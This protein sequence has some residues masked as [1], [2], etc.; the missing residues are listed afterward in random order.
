MSDRITA[1]EAAWRSALLESSLDC[2]ILMDAAGVIIDVNTGVEA[3]FGTLRQDIIGRRLGDV[4]V[5][6]ELRARHEEGLQRY[7]TRGES[8]ILGRRIEV[9]ALHANGS[10]MAV[11]LSIVHLQGTDPAVFVGHLRTIADRRRSERRLRLGAAAGGI[12]STSASPEAAVH[13]V[14]RA[15]GDELG[16]PLVQFWRVDPLGE[17]LELHEWWAQSDVPSPLGTRALRRGE[18]LPGATWARGEAIWIEDVRDSP[19]VLPRTGILDLAGVQS[20]VCF[21]VRVQ[22]EIVAVIEAFRTDRE[23]IDPELLP[24]LEVLGAQLGHVVAVHDA[25]RLLEANRRALQDALGRAERANAAKDEFLA[26]VSHELRTP[27]GPIMGWA[28]FLQQTHVDDTARV[29]AADVILRN[30]Q[31]ETRLVE[32]LLDVSRIV[33]GKLTIERT[34]VDVTSVVEAAIETVAGPA[35][36]KGLQI[37]VERG[38]EMPSTLGDPKRLQQVFSNLLVNA[39]KFTP[40]G[41]RITVT[42][43]AGPETVEVR[44]RDTGKGITS[45]LLPRI[46]ERFR[47]GG[48]GAGFASSG[49]GIGLSLVRDLVAAHGG[50]VHAASDGPG[51][52]ATFTVTLPRSDE[53]CAS[54]A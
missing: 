26:I 12:L 31:L 21:P 30:V 24:L 15:V 23:P 8:R 40:E 53:A 6:P 17:T 29:R 36:E 27:L 10:R 4:F 44:V 42:T 1:S 19:F 34:V 7:L 41:G 50:S 20:A 52:G 16:W 35:R 46:F 2:V 28:R 51:A 45:D 48:H 5:P 32:D 13:G 25:R 9:D 11:E 47:Q 3:S 43:S 18:G 49:L 37:D 38:V 54:G 14:L 39:V 33:A 22:S